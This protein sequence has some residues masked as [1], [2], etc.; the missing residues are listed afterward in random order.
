[1]AV[2]GEC[3]LRSEVQLFLSDTTS[4]E[5]NR[6]TDE[7]WLSRLAYLEDIFCHLSELNKSLQGLRTT[8][9]SVHDKTKD[10]RKILGFISMKYKVDKNLPFHFWVVSSV[11]MKFN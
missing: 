1:V 6:F 5:S 4:D 8:P 7:M 10:F 11:K 9:F 2:T 3:V